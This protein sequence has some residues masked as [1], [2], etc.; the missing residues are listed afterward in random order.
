M[1]DRLAIAIIIKGNMHFW[2]IA[3]AKA[4]RFSCRAIAWTFARLAI[5][6]F[7]VYGLMTQ[8]GPY[9]WMDKI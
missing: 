6:S 3:K 2:V 8:P 1:L 5:A 7:S 9:S 4:R